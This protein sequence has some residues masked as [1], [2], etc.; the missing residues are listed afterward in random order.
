MVKRSKGRRQKYVIAL[1]PFYVSDRWKT[2]HTSSTQ[3][4]RTSRRTQVVFVSPRW[5]GYRLRSHWI[6]VG[7]FLRIFIIVHS[8]RN[9]TGLEE[10]EDPAREVN[11]PDHL[12]VNVQCHWVENEWWEF[13]LRMPEES[14]I[15]QWDC[16]KDIGHSWVQGRRRSGMHRI[17]HRQKGAT[18]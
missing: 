6:R 4:E 2:L 13:V 16:Q 1:I 11:G 15:T 17:V 12:L 7:K 18:I 10:A 5:S 9:P 14:R 3:M 8:W